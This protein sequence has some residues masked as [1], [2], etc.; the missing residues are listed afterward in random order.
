MSLTG[1]GTEAER[2]ARMIEKKKREFREEGE[3]EEEKEEGG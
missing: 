1:M 2:E 3:D